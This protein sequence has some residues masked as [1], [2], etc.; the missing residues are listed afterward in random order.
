MALQTTGPISANDINVELGRAGTAPFSLGGTEER[1]LAGVASGLIT[2]NDFYG[3]SSA[4]V[5]LDGLSPTYYAEDDFTCDAALSFFSDGKIELVVTGFDEW[6][7]YLS[8][9]WY[10]PLSTGIG[11][12]YDIRF[13][14][15]AGVNP[16]LGGL[17]MGTW[18]RLNATRTV[19]LRRTTPGW[20]Y[21]NLTVT[22]RDAVS[23]ATVATGYT[24]FD[25]DYWN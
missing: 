22:I 10:D 7:G 15:T 4:G 23:L 16:N 19:G 12:S 8:P 6:D 1:A 21:C 13:V 2:F 5:T 9:G 3:A 11:N 20:S 25:V 24:G 17:T 18:Y 14:R